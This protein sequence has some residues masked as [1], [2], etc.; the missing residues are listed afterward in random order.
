MFPTPPLNVDQTTDANSYFF[1]GWTGWQV[2]AYVVGLLL[3]VVGVWGLS[4]VMDWWRRP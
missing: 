1:T 4:E 3:L 2:A